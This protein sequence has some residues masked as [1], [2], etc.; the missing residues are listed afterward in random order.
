[1]GPYFSTLAK[2]L[3]VNVNVNFTLVVFSLWIYITTTRPLSKIQV[4]EIV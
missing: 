4:N 3:H 1:M 2:E